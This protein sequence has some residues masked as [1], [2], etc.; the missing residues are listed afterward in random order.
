[1]TGESAITIE[2]TRSMEISGESW[3]PAGSPTQITGQSGGEETPSVMTCVY[4]LLNIRCFLVTTIFLC[5]AGRSHCARLIPP[6]YGEEVLENL[7]SD[8]WAPHLSEE[9]VAALG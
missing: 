5:S 3:Q 4:Q 8:V 6:L 2:L 9:A 1:M 7:L